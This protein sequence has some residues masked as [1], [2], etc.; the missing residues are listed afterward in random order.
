[1]SEIGETMRLHLIL[2]KPTSME[3]P[4]ARALKC[5]KVKVR[6]V[7][8]YSPLTQMNA[9]LYRYSE[10]QNYGCRQVNI[11]QGLSHAKF[12]VSARCIGL[13]RSTRDFGHEWC[14]IPA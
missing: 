10:R 11:S 8:F 1:M 2:G 6:F 14:N 5:L 7:S 13:S 12:D 3:G 9:P 4:Q